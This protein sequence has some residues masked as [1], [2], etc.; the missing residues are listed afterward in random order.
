MTRDELKPGFYKYWQWGMNVGLPIEIDVYQVDGEWLW[1]KS[2]D[3]GNW[4]SDDMLPNL[5]WVRPF[6]GRKE[7][8]IPGDVSYTQEEYA[9]WMK[10][11]EAMPDP[12]SKPK[13]ENG[14]TRD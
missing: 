6:S 7:L 9:R 10:E 4:V 12:D 11:L 13:G 2:D 5:H 1:G 3:C 14:E 8:I